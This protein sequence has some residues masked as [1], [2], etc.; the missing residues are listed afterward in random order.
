MSDQ[1]E[2]T[3]MRLPREEY[4]SFVCVEDGTMLAEYFP[5]QVYAVLH[6]GKVL[7]ISSRYTEKMWEIFGD[8]PFLK[9]APLSSGGPREEG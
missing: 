9:F 8:E 2:L 4:E 3:L 6:E 5:E 1:V 7:E